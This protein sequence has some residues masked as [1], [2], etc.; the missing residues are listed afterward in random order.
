MLLLYF[1]LPVPFGVEAS[2]MGISVIL[3]CLGF[4]NIHWSLRLYT[5]GLLTTYMSFSLERVSYKNL[6][7]YQKRLIQMLYELSFICASWFCG[8]LLGMHVGI[9]INFIPSD[10]TFRLPSFL[11]YLE[12]RLFFLTVA[13]GIFGFIWTNAFFDGLTVYQSIATIVENHINEKTK[14]RCF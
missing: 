14:Y 3:F 2:M 11:S 13:F 9:R 1:F 10:Y 7:F 4:F 5:V 8:A 12:R 6:I